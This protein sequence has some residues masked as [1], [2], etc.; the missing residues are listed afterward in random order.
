MTGAL[1]VPLIE[2]YP[3]EVSVRRVEDIAGV[4]FDG[5]G[6][7]QEDLR[8]DRG[9]AQSADRGRSSVHGIV[10]KRCTAARF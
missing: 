7:E 10:L 2:M 4:A 6:P 3:A 5:V 8:N 9:M 1:P